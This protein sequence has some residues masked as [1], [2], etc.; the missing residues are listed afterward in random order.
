MVMK[1][2]RRRKWV[3]KQL[4]KEERHFSSHTGGKEKGMN[5]DTDFE[6]KKILMTSICS[7]KQEAL[8]FWCV[9]IG[10]LGVSS[11]G[12]ESRN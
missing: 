9:C 3:S 10:F 6:V 5:C 12:A 7:I 11:S 8:V 2:L 4:E 1:D